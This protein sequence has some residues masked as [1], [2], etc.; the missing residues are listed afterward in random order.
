M[1]ICFRPG[2]LGTKPDALT[3]CPDLYPKGEGKPFG[4]VNP[5]NCHPVFSSMQLSASLQATKMFLVVLCGVQAMDIELQK[6]IIAAYDIDPSV[7]SFCADPE[8]TKYSQWS[9]DDV[10]FV[11][12]DQGIYVPELGDL[13]L[14][15]LQSF[16]DHPISGHYGVNKTLSVI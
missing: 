13:Q 2:C 5:Q 12:I 7:Q 8:N 14:R 6:D 4:T 1:V 10:G 16:H 11:Q 15:V 9:E 3:R